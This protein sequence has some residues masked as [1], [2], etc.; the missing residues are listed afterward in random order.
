[1]AWLCTSLYFCSFFQLSELEDRNKELLKERDKLFKELDRTR[2]ELVLA[3]T[4][5][6]AEKIAKKVK[7]ETKRK[8]SIKGA[9][10]PDPTGVSKALEEKIAEKEQLY[11]ELRDENDVR[12]YNL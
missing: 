9:I 5:T 8:L 1:M 2:K 10:S 3:K 4:K 11:E 12:G 7:K 6:E